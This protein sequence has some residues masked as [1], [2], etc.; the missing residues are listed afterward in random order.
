MHIKEAIKK[1]DELR[2]NAISEERKAHWVYELEGRL[3]HV[4]RAPPPAKIW[5]ADPALAMP[6][7]YDTVYE[8]YLCAMI[9]LMN[10]ETALYANDMAVFEETYSA[11]VAWLRRRRPPG[12]YLNWKVM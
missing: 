7:P 1:A 4:R 2:P 11:A 12:P 5:P 3:A 10:Q 8:R 6:P 9:D